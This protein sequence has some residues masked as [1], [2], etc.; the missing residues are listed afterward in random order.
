MITSLKNDKVRLVRALQR[1]RRVRQRERCFVIE[2]VRLGEEATEAGVLPH[3]AFY[4]SEIQESLRVAALLKSWREAGVP[5]IEVSR[6]VMEA[7]SDTEAPQGL[8]AVVPIPDLP[9]PAR[10]TLTLILD[11]LRDPGNMGTILRTALAAGVEQALIPPGT[12]DATNPKVVRAGMGA[13]FRLPLVTMDWDRIPQA[14]AGCRVYLAAARGTVPYTEV[15]WTESVA[16]VVGGEAA[17]AGKRAH[18]LADAE[19]TIPLAEG[20]ESLNAAVAAA[21]ILFEAVRQ[22]RMAG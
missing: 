1:R 4:T 15:D 21:V 17:G 11:R 2:G 20:V 19:V 3:F 13:H 22:R 9:R 8:L 5:C 16:L 7:C 6:P 14:V 12:V 18:A 10:P